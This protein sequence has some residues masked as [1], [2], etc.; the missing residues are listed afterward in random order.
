MKPEI[1]PD[2]Q[3]LNLSLTEAKV[4]ATL[5]EIG[6]TSAGK[7]I[8]STSLHRSVVYET[9]E[10]LINKKIVIKVTKN[11]ISFYQATDPTRFIDNAHNQLE[12]AQKL[13]P[14]LKEMIDMKL[15]EI[16]VYQGIQSYRRFWLDSYQKLPVG[17]IDYIS[18]SVGNKWM[19]LMG[20]S[21]ESVMEARIKR[22]IIWKMIV[23]EHNQIEV[24]LLKKYPLLH[25][26]RLINKEI[27]RFGNFNIFEGISVILQ[28][29]TEPTIIEIKNQ[30]LVKVFQNIFD[31]LWESGEEIK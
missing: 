13:V 20:N 21:Y 23:L 12:L 28:S 24:D 25:E 3:Q 19:E 8:N 26:Y 18:N 29:T 16:T 1:L 31:I 14:Q 9:L 7:I 11:N 30:T 5:L 4:Y 17:T 6:Q 15:P 27:H 2:L 22:K 10:K